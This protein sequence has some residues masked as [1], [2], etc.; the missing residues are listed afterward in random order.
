M[1]KQLVGPVYSEHQLGKM[2]IYSP[3]DSAAGVL[4]SFEI[5]DHADDQFAVDRTDPPDVF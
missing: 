5:L 4:V 1:S 2:Q 3:T